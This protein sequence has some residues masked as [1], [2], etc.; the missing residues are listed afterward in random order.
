MA[1]LDASAWMLLPMAPALLGLNTPPSPTLLNQCFAV[2]LWGTGLIALARADGHADTRTNAALCLAYV[3]LTFGVL[4][5]VALGELP[6]SLALGPLLLLIC[7]AAVTARAASVGSGRSAIAVM[8]W[9]QL[10]F[11][12]VGI[13]SAAVGCIQVFAP[14]W[15][16]GDWIAR[17]SLP[18]RAVGNLRQPNHLSTLLLWSLIGVAGLFELHCLRRSWA[19]ATGLL[20]TFVLVLTGSRTGVLGVLILAAWGML[21]RRL[22]RTARISLI[23]SPVVCGAMWLGLS[24]WG[25]ITGHTFSAENR[26]LHG[27]GDISSSR[28]AI[29]SNAVTML[30]REPLTGVGFGEFNL[31]WTLSQ[32]P[33][34][35]TAFFDHTHNLPLQLMVEL[36]I[37][38]GLV[39]FGLLLVALWQARRRAWACDGALGVAKRAAF[40]VV[41]TIGLHSLLEYPLWYAYFLLP[42]AFAWGF[43]LSR[44]MPEPPSAT[45]VKK[46]HG[47]RAWPAIGAAMVLGAISA[48]LDYRLVAVIYEPPE[49]A[50]PLEE[51]ICRGQHSPLYGHH[52]DYAA[53]TAFGPPAA[54]LSA[55]QELAFRRAPHQLLDVRLMIAWAQALAAQG[56]LDKARWLAARVREFR[57]FDA[58]EFFAPCRDAVLA[59]RPFQCE[60]PSHAVEWRAFTRD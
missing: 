58:N 56:K 11:V 59:A 20:L 4:A 6:R 40:M 37:P 54:P 48:S 55:A 17:T 50:A 36:G 33:D 57:S 41:L 34:R 60:L 27:G 45:A 9:F 46:H 24:A 35:P 2:G 14:A 51:R 5:T 10:G 21:D 23:A 12:I 8:Q 16:D 47:Q 29:W 13:V 49:H 28:F 18:G 22:S 43:A 42:T 3:V 32:F 26:L 31:A 53:A 7:A 44:P 1:R 30:A 52:A 38:L 15:P 39:S 25:H 19:L